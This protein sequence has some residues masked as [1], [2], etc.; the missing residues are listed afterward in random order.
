[1]RSGYPGNDGPRERCLRLALAGSCPFQRKKT[2]W[3]SP[4]INEAATIRSTVTIPSSILILP[5]QKRQFD[6]ID[7]NRALI[8]C[9]LCAIVDPPLVPCGW[10]R[11]FRDG[12]SKKSSL[13]SLRVSVSSTR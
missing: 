3:Y 5:E 2:T 7:Q 4:G 11:T 9:Y 8:Q 6:T 12:T 1:V 10:M 13:A